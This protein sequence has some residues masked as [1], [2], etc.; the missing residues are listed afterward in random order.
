MNFGE[1]PEENGSM[2]PP[3]AAQDSSHEL[4]TVLVLTTWPADRDPVTLASPLVEERLAACVN[5]WPVMESVYR[6]EGAVQREP[7]RQLVIKTTAA[8]LDALY[9]K[10]RDLHPYEV[11]EFLVIEI[12]GGSTPYLDWVR[13]SVRPAGE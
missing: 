6:W 10:L 5:A 2:T 3:L 9:A 4:R 1:T 13:S 8:R 12:A 11:P 7:E